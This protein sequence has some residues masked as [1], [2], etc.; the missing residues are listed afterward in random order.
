ML[1]GFVVIAIVWPVEGKEYPSSE[2]GRPELTFN[3]YSEAK[4][5][6]VRLVFLENVFVSRP[7]PPKLRPVRSIKRSFKGPRV[8]STVPLAISAPGPRTNG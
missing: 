4:L 2:R 7:A 1:A 5:D 6:N 8:I 3:G